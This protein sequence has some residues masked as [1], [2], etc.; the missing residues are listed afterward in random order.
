MIPLFPVSPLDG[1]EPI[2]HKPLNESL[3]AF[4]NHRIRVQGGEVIIKMY[5]VE[6]P[7]NP[8]TIPPW[9]APEYRTL[10]C[11]GVSHMTIEW[12]SGVPTCSLVSYNIQ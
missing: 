10:R 8:I 11:A 12:G 5:L 6:D 2:V 7:T 4:E 9:T 1:D 3:T